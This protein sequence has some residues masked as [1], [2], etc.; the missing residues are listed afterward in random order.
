MNPIWLLL[1]GLA[2]G[3]FWVWIGLYLGMRIGRRSAECSE[4]LESQHVR[5]LLGEL[6]QWTTSFQREVATYREEMEGFSEQATDLGRGSDPS[7]ATV[8]L[9]LLTQILSSNQRLQK[10][11]HDAE[12][13]LTRQSEELC[14]YLSEARTDSLT[15]LPNRRALDEELLRR[16]AEWRRYKAPF[17]VALLDIDRF[18]DINDRYGH[19]VGDEVLREVARALRGSMRDADLVSRFG[20]EEFAILMPATS[21]PA[22]FIAAERAREAVQKVLIEVDGVEIRP[23][24]SCGAAQA[25]ESDDATTLL[26]RADAAL[27]TSKYAG[28]NQCHWHDGQRCIPIGTASLLNATAELSTCTSA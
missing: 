1:A 20:G 28:R 10:R 27:Y 21:G 26:Q 9:Q 4:A 6:S 19:V 15:A 16:L 13:R 22:T 2:C 7:R 11:L 12:N 5:Q 17:S 8:V 24:V 14:E 3:A 18:K 23:T 25:S